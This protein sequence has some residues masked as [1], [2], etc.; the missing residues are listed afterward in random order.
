MPKTPIYTAMLPESARHVMGVPHPS[1]RAAMRMLEREGFAYDCYID[2]FDG[3]PTM[4]ARTEQIRT[5]RDS[6]EH[7]LSAIEEEVEGERMLLAAGKLSN[8]AA[9]Y[10]R[11][12]LG[13]EGDATLD[14]QT[15]GLLNIQP[16]EPFLAMG[17]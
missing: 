10:G 8:F 7:V 13:P 2:I 15:A 12:A 5:I 16:G 4:S 9:C 3:G 17:R 11:L 1:G 6:Q 14:A